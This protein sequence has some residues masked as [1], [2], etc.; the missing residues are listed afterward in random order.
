MAGK[1]GAAARASLEQLLT[2]L[3]DGTAETEELPVVVKADVQGSVEAVP[4]FSFVS[5]CSR[6]AR[7]AAP[8][9]P[10]TWRF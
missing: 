3:K 8:A 5:S 6:E 4:S 1:A 10:A 9:F 2:K 7:A